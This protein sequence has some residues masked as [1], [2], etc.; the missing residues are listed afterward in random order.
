MPDTAQPPQGGGAPRPASPAGGPAR[1]APPGPA[2]FGGPAR[3]GSPAAPAP[4]RPAPPAAGGS[5]PQQ[6][7]PGGGSGSYSPNSGYKY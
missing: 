5:F 4:G 7:R 2:S 6:Q 3:P 1:P